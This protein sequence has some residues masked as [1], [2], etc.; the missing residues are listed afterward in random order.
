MYI[1]N[2][3]LHEKIYLVHMIELFQVNPWYSI[4]KD[5]N[6]MLREMVRVSSLE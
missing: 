2:S 3:E 5:L 6:R 1:I 4:Q